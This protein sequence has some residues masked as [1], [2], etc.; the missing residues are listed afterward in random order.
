MDMQAHC[1][2]GVVDGGSPRNSRRSAANKPAPLSVE[3]SAA[4]RDELLAEVAALV[5]GHDVDTWA[6]AAL[7][8]KNTLTAADATADRTGILGKVVRAEILRRCLMGS[9]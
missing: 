6:T 9:P 2:T 7:Q 3:A 5:T 8:A 1:S 4:R